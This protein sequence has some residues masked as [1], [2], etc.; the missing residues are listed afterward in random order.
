MNITKNVVSGE[1]YVKEY[2]LSNPLTTNKEKG[3]SV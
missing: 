3:D 2:M 1:L